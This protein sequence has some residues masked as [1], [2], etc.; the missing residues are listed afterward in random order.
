[1]AQGRPLILAELVADSNAVGHELHCRPGVY[2]AERVSDVLSFVD[3]VLTDVD[4]RA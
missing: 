2:V 1:M 4:V 3:E